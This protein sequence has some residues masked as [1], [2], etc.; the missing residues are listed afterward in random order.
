MRMAGVRRVAAARAR[1]EARTAAAAWAAGRQG[2]RQ[3]RGGARAS[4]RWSLLLLQR[5]LFPPFALDQ[6]RP[7]S[8]ASPEPCLRSARHR[9]TCN[10]LRLRPASHTSQAALHPDPPAR[11]F[12]YSRSWL[13]RSRESPGGLTLVVVG[14]GGALGVGV[15]VGVGT[16]VAVVVVVRGHWVHPQG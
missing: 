16:V 14:G 9:S 10:D 11:A 15:G 7:P 8:P 2:N 5:P 3:R 4:D 13:S 6:T 1:P 12:G